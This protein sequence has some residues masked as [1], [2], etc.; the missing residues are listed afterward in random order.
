MSNINGVRSKVRRRMCQVAGFCENGNE[1][2]GFLKA[3]RKLFSEER[4]CS[5]K[6]VPVI[7]LVI[8][9]V[10]SGCIFSDFSVLFYTRVICLVLC[11]KL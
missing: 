4:F 3:W 7:Q 6:F 5:I 2:L 1:P 10:S 9:Y 8:P 11:I